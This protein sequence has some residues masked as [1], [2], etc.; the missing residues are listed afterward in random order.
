[1]SGQCMSVA[2]GA[3]VSLFVYLFITGAVF[4]GIAG[5][6]GCVPFSNYYIPGVVLMSITGALSVIVAV[7]GFCF[8][9][10]VILPGS[11]RRG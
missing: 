10:C 1:M 11:G 3:I 8:L 6:D 9:I 5:R 7:G 4:V 2:G